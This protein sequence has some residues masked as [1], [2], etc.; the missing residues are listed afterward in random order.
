MQ[1]RAENVQKIVGD[2]FSS[3]L[4]GDMRSGDTVGMWTYNDEL[5]TGQFPLQRWTK[6]TRQ[7]VAV[8]MVQFLQQQKFEK[9]PRPSVFWE[10]LTNIVANSER[11]TVV[12]VSSGSEPIKGTPFDESIVQNYLKNDEAQRKAKMPFVT[13]LRAYQGKFVSFSVCLPPWPMEL[14]DYPKEARRAPEPAAVKPAPVAVKPPPVPPMPVANHAPVYATNLPVV[15]PAIE[16]AAT[17]I[18]PSTPEPTPA[19]TNEIAT[20]QPEPAPR[21]P[22]KQNPETPSAPVAEKKPPLPIVTILVAGIALLTAIMVVFLALLRWTKRSSG[23][24]LITRTMNKR[25]E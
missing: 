4:G 7:R 13:I 3:G 23:E 5:Q 1:K 11:I 18:A 16:L 10:A 22:A 19:R 21:S 6:T 8:T 2:M 15:E 9:M 20:S 25:D 17:N 24:S 14:P 12:I